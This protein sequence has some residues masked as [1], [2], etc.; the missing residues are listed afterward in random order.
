VASESVQLRLRRELGRAYVPSR[1]LA[2]PRLWVDNK[3]KIS[4]RLFSLGRVLQRHQLGDD[5]DGIYMQLW[6]VD[7]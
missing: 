3:I 4:I 2:D 6:H 5:W 1:T 7:A